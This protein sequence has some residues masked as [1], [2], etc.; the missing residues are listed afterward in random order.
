MTK[1][2]TG[3]FDDIGQAQRAVEDLVESG[4]SRED[5]SLVAADPNEEYGRHFGPYG[6]TTYEQASEAGSGA[7]TGAVAGG[8]LGGLGGI[9]LGLGAL[10]IPGVG[11]VIAA[12]PIAAGLV[13]AGVGAAAG[14]LVGAL[15]GWGIPEEEAHYYTEGVRRGGTL[16]AVRTPDHQVSRVADILGAYNPVNL[17][18]RVETWRSSGWSGYDPDAEPYTAAE[19]EAER[20]RYY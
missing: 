6:E 11:P 14:G 20:E 15:I 9:L 17:D 13:G 3:L 10:A 4:F 2:V 7:A 16:V 8:I 18:E 19:I 12:G 1:T 5:I